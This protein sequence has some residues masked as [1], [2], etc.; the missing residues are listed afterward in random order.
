M[1]ALVYCLLGSLIMGDASEQPHPLR[2]L[3]QADGRFVL[4]SEITETKS[5]GGTTFVSRTV[6]PRET[7]TLTL[8]FDARHRLTSARAVQEAGKESHTL[9]ATFEGTTAR[10]RRSTGEPETVA[11]VSGK[12]IVTTAPDWSDILQLARRYDRTKGGRQQF[13]GLWIHP[14]KPA[15]KL[16]FTIEGVARDSVTRE[17]KTFVLQR[18]R[19]RLRSGEYLAWA[20]GTGRVLKLMVPGK[21]AG[22]VV[23]EGFQDVAGGLG[24]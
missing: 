14:V 18:Y 6:R 15:R 19:I 9:A 22:A 1:A 16:T 3:R 11:G 4:E 10:L 2:Y 17:N 13:A 12:A 20:D 8:H 23:L 21:P 24:K 5:K 7:M